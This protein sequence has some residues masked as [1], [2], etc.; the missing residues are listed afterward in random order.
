GEAIARWAATGVDV[1]R[2]RNVTVT[3]TDLAGP[4]L[5][6]AWGNTIWLDLNAAGWGWFID[7]TPADA[8]EFTT[9]GN[10]GEQNRMD[11]LTLLEHET[12]HLLGHDH[13]AEGL[14]APTLRDGRRHD[15][16]SGGILFDVAAL[17]RVFSDPSTTLAVPCADDP[18]P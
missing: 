15:P 1:S 8:R 17:D 16:S 5:G 13:E 12:G 7:P 3:I 2:L 9:P 18:V 14:M 6:L 10:Q 11:L 4:Q